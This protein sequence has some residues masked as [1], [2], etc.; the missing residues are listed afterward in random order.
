MVHD[1]LYLLL[2]GQETVRNEKTQ[3]ELW[4]L[5]KRGTH[6]KVVEI[7][8]CFFSKKMWVTI[9]VVE[10]NVNVHYTRKDKQSEVEIVIMQNL[11][12]SISIKIRDNTNVQGTFSQ[13]IGNNGRHNFIRETI[14]RIIILS[15]D[16]V[17]HVEGIQKN[18]PQV[19]QK[20][21][22]G[23]LSISIFTENYIKYWIKAE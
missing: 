7:H 13:I 3:K 4:A 12:K 19:P 10:K 9:T 11:Y 16:I 15:L 14:I 5:I 1:F 17:E 18:I 23:E 21:K 2:Q 6:N 8:K 20:V 22:L